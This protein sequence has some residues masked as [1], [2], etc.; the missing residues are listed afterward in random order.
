[1]I[2]T[3]TKTMETASQEL[4]RECCYP[5]VTT[6]MGLISHLEVEEGMEIE[7]WP[8]IHLAAFLI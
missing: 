5:S 4:S 3:L 7:R 6:R 2:I 1:M 8:K